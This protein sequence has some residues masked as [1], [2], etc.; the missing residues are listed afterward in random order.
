[1]RYRIDDFSVKEPSTLTNFLQRNCPFF[2]D[3]HEIKDWI[4]SSLVEVNNAQTIDP[5][6]QLHPKDTIHLY[7]PES[8]EPPV[9]KEYEILH[10]DEHIIIINKPA[11]LPIHPAGKYWFNTLSQLLIDDE[12]IKKN[13]IFPTHRLDRETSGIVIFA[14]D[15]ETAS[16]IQQDFANRMV[17]K[18]YIAICQGIPAQERG[19]ISKPL[20]K[21]T[22]EHLRDIMII[23]ENGREAI[24]D[25]EV[26]NTNPEK[27]FSL[28][29]LNPHTGRRHQ[30]RAHLA[31]IDCPIV[32]DK[33]Y[34]PHN[35]RYEDFI[36]EPERFK[37]EITEKLLT[38]R[39][40]LHCN[41]IRFTHPTTGKSVAMVAPL[42]EDMIQFCKKQQI[43]QTSKH[44][45]R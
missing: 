11:P 17:E 21:G 10:E 30:L 7:T 39:H 32:G 35:E 9:H 16:R 8:Y 45:N 25:F 37:E 3:D 14:K 20:S 38:Q 6:I 18:E 28:V 34:G 27:S 43:H 33:L 19:T 5:N 40:L 12:K 15:K 22:R 29:R 1:M 4:A 42:P 26:V 2:R 13:E 36:R 31:S 44:Y 41:K 24:T 23:D